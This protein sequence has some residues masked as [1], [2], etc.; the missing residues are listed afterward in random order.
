[1]ER[2]PEEPNFHEISEK[3]KELRGAISELGDKGP[4]FEK[5]YKKPL[6]EADEEASK[7]KVEDFGGISGA[8]EVLKKQKSKYEE[9]FSEDK[10]HIDYEAILKVA[11]EVGE[12]QKIAE[13]IADVFEVAYA[14]A[15]AYGI[16][17]DQIE[18]AR[19][20]KKELRGGFD[21]KV[22]STYIEMDMHNKE[23]AYYL[24]RPEKYPEMV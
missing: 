21:G 23:S 22:Y 17:Y 20:H 10:A 1:M 12:V 14:L 9:D 3:R 13:E 24:A 5:H 11:P 15:D 2:I 18:Q 6:A 7:F 19:L 8:K 16:N 4:I